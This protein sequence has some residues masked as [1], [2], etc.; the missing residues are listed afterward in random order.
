[1]RRSL[2]DKHKLF[3]DRSRQY[4]EFFAV[5]YGNSGCEESIE[6]EEIETLIFFSNQVDPLNST[7]FAGHL[8]FLNSK[9]E[10][11]GEKEKQ[12]TFKLKLE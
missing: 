1:M 4:E 3:I 2:N 5:H 8:I 9:F 11:G 6:E 12:S 10:D 7:S